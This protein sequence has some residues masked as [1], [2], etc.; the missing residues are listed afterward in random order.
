MIRDPFPAANR[1]GPDAGPP[2]RWTWAVCLALAAITFAVFGQTVD[3]QFVNFDDAIYVVNNSIVSRGLTWKGAAQVFTGLNSGNWHPLTMLSHMLDCQIYGLHPAGHHLSNV[4]LHAAAAIAL[5]LVLRSMT[6]AFWRSAFVA[7][8]FAIHPLRVESVAWVAERKDVLSGLFFSL[9]IGAYVHY[10]RRPWSSANYAL[11]AFV[12]A[13]GLMCKPMLVTL[14]LVLLVLDFWP[15]QR[16]RPPFLRR[17]I[18]EK[19]PLLALAALVCAATLQAQSKAIHAAEIYSIPARLANAL[20]SSI[21]YLRQIFWPSGLAVLYPFPRNGTPAGEIVLAGVLF[22]GIS[23]LVWRERGARPWLLAGWAWYLVMLIPVAGI[24]QV[25]RQGHADRYT[26]LPQIGISIAVTW[27]VAE[28]RLRRAFL[29]SLIVG[30]IAVLM[31]VAWK[32]TTYW[33]DSVTLWTR[34]LACTTDNET[35]HNNLGTALLDEGKPEEA[36]RQ[37]EIALKLWPEYPFANFNLGMAQL[38]KG[39][40]D[41][42]IAHFLLCLKTAP[43][44]ADAHFRLGDA[45]RQK[46]QINEAIAEYQRALDLRPDLAEAENNL[47]STL[48]AAGRLDEAIAHYEKA[49][50]MMPESDDIHFNL[51]RTFQQKGDDAQ[52]IHYFEGALQIQPNDIETLND[53]AWLRATAAQESLRNGAEAVELARKANDLAHAQNPAVLGTLA[54]AL[55]EKKDFPGAVETARHGIKL[56]NTTTNTALARTIESQMKFYEAGQPFRSH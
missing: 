31:A 16:L 30:V 46:G 3:H 54:A 17:R 6:G 19:L 47:A 12:Y 44:Y 53:L 13:L 9:T 56:A 18:A 28:W 37:F 25:G 50:A 26:Y 11:I 48:R 27:L 23:T 22:L 38:R 55:A 34:A 4:L 14:P 45:L 20:I 43:N 52:A 42:A 29:G 10:A 24:I 35:A 2:W 32:Q 8:V 5:F 51:A 49:L 21:I 7:A 33:Q 40:V 41:D 39:E 36:Q 15:L 1:P